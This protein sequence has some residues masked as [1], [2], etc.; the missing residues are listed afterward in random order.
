MQTEL[1][2]EQEELRSQ[3][4]KEQEMLYEEEA[5]LQAAQK[6]NERNAD[7][8]TGEMFAECQVYIHDSTHTLLSCVVRHSKS[9]RGHSCTLAVLLVQ[10]CLNWTFFSWKHSIYLM[11][12]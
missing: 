6:K 11:S 2:E 12:K 8:V 4:R 7:S 1:E 3:I 9:P 5:E 10:C